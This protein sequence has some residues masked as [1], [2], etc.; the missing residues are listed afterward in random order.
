MELDHPN[1]VKIYESYEN[2]KFFWIVLELCNGGELFDAIAERGRFSEDEARTTF[3][4]A[5]LSINQ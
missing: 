1:V 3:H 4:N 2:E 5:A